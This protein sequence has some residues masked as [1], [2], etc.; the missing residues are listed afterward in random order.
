MSSSLA[1]ANALDPISLREL[2]HKLRQPLSTIETYVSYL[3]LVLPDEQGTRVH[4]Q[5]EA[6]AEQV[7]EANRILVESAHSG[8]PRRVGSR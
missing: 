5:L 3:Q 6:I 7:E 2:I 8:A 1:E 4:A